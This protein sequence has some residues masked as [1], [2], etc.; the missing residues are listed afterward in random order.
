MERKNSLWDAFVSSLKWYRNLKADRWNII[1]MTYCNWKRPGLEAWRLATIDK[2]EKGKVSKWIDHF[3]K[4]GSIRFGSKKFRVYQMPKR[5][6][7][8]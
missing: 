6:D 5:K 1:Y 8:A 4:I 2:Q 3:E 7:E